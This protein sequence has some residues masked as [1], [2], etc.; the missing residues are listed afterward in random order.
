MV[1]DSL[2]SNDQGQ[3][4]KLSPLAFSLLSLIKGLP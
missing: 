4:T 2:M 3:M 1:V